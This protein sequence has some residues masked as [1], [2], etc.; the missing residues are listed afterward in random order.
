MLN[1]TPWA[2][3]FSFAVFGILVGSIQRWF[4]QLPRGDL[5]LYVAPPLGM[6]T[7][8]ALAGDSDQLLYMVCT[9]LVI[10]SVILRLGARQLAPVRLPFSSARHIASA[11]PAPANNL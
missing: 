1:F 8:S 10:P 2:I 4:E 9:T 7:I 11:T 3:P 5:R 6:F